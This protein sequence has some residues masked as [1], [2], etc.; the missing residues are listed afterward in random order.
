MVNHELY[1]FTK[2]YFSKNNLK[3]HY[4]DE[5]QGTPVVMVHGNPTWSFY[6]RNLV[7]L[8]RN[9]H[10]CIV[11]DHIGCG[12]SDKP[13]DSAYTYTLK[14]RIDDLDDLLAHLGIDEQITLIVH[15]WGGMIGMGYASRYPD[16][17]KRIVVLNTAAFHLPT[18][19]AFPAALWLG[20]NT[21]LGAFL[22]RGFNMFCRTAARV[23]VK[24]HPLPAEIKEAYLAP[25]DNW[26]NRIAVARFVQ[27]IPL[28]QGDPGYDIVSDIA[29]GLER[30]KGKPMLI[31]WGLKDFVFSHQFLAEWQRR[32]PEA[33]VHSFPDRGHYILEDASEEV[34]NLIQDFFQRHPVE[35]P[36]GAP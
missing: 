24:A 27:D 30:F 5:G 10:R 13:D 21:G 7:K 3:L 28:K 11:P 15:D 26:A 19:K 9:Q 12:F 36:A 6:Y 22:I 4:L 2:H 35:V 18:N 31:C 33:E 20:R 1:P 34:H 17:I 8:L 23:C 29:N 25:Y 32:F 16:R 14:S